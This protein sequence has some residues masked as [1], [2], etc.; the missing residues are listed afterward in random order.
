MSSP[1]SPQVADPR[2][3]SPVAERIVAYSAVLVASFFGLVSYGSL[4]H[5]ARADA[6]GDALRYLEMSG[7]TFA[8]VE[9]PFAFR[10]L[11]PW[12][13]QQLSGV[14]GVAPD[15]VWLVLTFVASTA[16]IVVV[17][18]FLRRPLGISAG[19]S[20]WSVLLLT[21]TYSYT[22][23][24]YGNFWL[25]DP[26]ANLFMA[27]ALFF[28]FQRRLLPFVLVVLVGMVNKETILLVAPL[29][30]LLQ[31]ARSG[32]LRD[33]SVV[34]SGVATAVIGGCYLVFR[35]WAHARIGDTETWAGQGVVDIARAALSSRPR[36]EH[37]AVFVVF[38]FLWPVFA[39]G[40]YRRFRH[41]GVRDGL[42][43]AGLYLF[44]CCLLGRVQ[45]T[46]TDRVFVMMA[47]LVIAVAATV[48]DDLRGEQQRL[49]LWILGGVYAALN[50]SWLTGELATVAN[51]A[52]LALVVLMLHPP[53]CS[54]AITGGA[55]PVGLMA[56]PGDGRR[57]PDLLGH[58]RSPARTVTA[59]VDERP[60]PV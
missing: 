11:T 56:A 36:R 41:G 8:A 57:R 50:F 19:V 2:P 4:E 26:L 10:L 32:S 23:Y 49:W 21:V 40:L 3:L 1:S 44:T 46:D 28:A 45:A 35:A 48:F 39:Y 6:R 27:L 5:G 16:A 55:S 18:E 42:L 12:L 58:T 25:V 17:Y 34:V 20:T 51:F 59:P 24:N 30:P 43:I 52:V 38:Q 9:S 7:D 31:W 54:C 33:R 37:L 29:F 22:S 15:T 60:V 53:S 47:P 13:V 14:S